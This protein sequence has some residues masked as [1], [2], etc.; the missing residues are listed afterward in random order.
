MIV[1]ALG[2]HVTL[3]YPPLFHLFSLAFFLAIPAVDPYLIMKIIV[4]ALD[5]VQVVP[6]YYIVRYVSKSSSAGAVAGLAAVV[7]PGD[8]LMISWGGY[9][10]IAGLLLIAILSYFVLKEEAVMVG[11]VSAIL[12][13]THHLSMLF[14]IALF[15]PYLLITWLRTRKLPRSL[16]SFVAAIGVAYVVFYWR[17]LIPLY[18]MYTQYAPRYATFTL[19][20]DWPF[21][22]GIPILV[23][24]A[25]GICLRLYRTRALPPRSDLLLYMWFLWPVLLGYSF[26]FGVRWDVIRWVYFLQQPACVWCGIAVAQFK[27]GKLAVAIV[28]LAFIVQWIGAIQGYYSDVKFNSGYTY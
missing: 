9:A 20:S 6:V 13:L 2:E 3:Y 8:L 28:L 23:V 17:T 22:L 14:A 7:A 24:A 26:L 11:I 27:K 25:L 4:S 21:M 18:D 19:R 12:F 5:A 15:L 10:N 16:V 1:T